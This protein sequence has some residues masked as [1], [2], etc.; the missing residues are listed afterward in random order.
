VPPERPDPGR[1]V[2]ETLLVRDGRIHALQLHLERLAH[3]LD[4]L[5]GLALPCDLPDAMR[6]RAGALTGEHRLR[7][8]VAARNGAAEWECASS[9]LAPGARRAVALAPATVPGGLGAHKW[10]DRRLIEALGADP[11]PLLVDVDGSVLEGAWGNLWLLDGDVLITPPAD[12]R[13]LPGVTRH[14]LLARAADLGLTATERAIPIE[15]ARAAPTPFLTSSLRL[16][17]AAAFDAPPAG[18]HPTLTRIR[19]ALGVF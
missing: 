4:A 1:G 17:V 18:E 13:I 9:P 19:D 15:E 10:A 14:L 6:A 16:I 12:G 7:V 8:D 2:F 11:V 3:S 5:Y